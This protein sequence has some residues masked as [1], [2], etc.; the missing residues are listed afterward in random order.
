M[1]GFTYSIAFDISQQSAL[2]RATSLVDKLDNAVDR[3]DDSID[4]TNSSMGRMG[5]EGASAFE[6]IRGSAMSFIATLGIA[7]FTMGSL[8]ASAEMEGVEK[9]ITFASAG[10]GARNLD[11]LDQSVNTLGLDMRYAASGFQMFLGGVQGTG[12]TMQQTRDIFYSVS[13]AAT[14]M[15]LS[16]EASEGVF[17]ALS[18]MASKGKV[19]AEELRGQLG[20]RL[21]GAFNIAARAMGVTTSELDKMLV[22]G[23]LMATDFLPRFAEELHRTFGA[24]VEDSANSARANFNRFNSSMLELRTTIGSQ[25]LPTVVGLIRDFFVPAVTWI[26]ENIRVLGL[27]ASIFGAVWAAAKLY[28]IGM[29]VASL[30]T[31]GATISFLGLNAAMLANPIT[32]VVGLL[33]A[34][35]AGVIYAWN[36]WEGFR[37]ALSGIWGVIKETGQLLL[38]WLITPLTSLGKIMVGVFTFDQSLVREGMA[39]AASFMQNSVLKAGE[40]LGNAFQQGYQQGVEGFNAKEQGPAFARP[41]ALSAA[42]GA[43]PAGPAASGAPAGAPTDQGLKDG[44]AG[45]TGGGKQQKN[46][47]INI[48]KFFDNVNVHG[49]DTA[50][51]ADQIADQV[52]RKLIQSLNSAN[53]IQ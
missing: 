23:E 6:R 20:E 53:Q 34:L 26:G 39:D 50:D 8:Q 38:E 14:V 37:G 17:L 44:I 48:S 22:K 32:W 42:F 36:K 35:T 2:A 10:E 31:G 29:A 51:G 11:F 5:R 24:Q 45:I 1:S 13:E 19:S 28:T 40:R 30:I 3:L 18:Q 4:E 16:G 33:V 27:L 21:P 12:I 47:T 41:D 25:L 9:A 46:I 52:M 49:A 15:N 7:A 43:T